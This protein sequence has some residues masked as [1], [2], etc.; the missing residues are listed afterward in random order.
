[1]LSSATLFHF[2]SSLETLKKILSEGFKPF[3][4]SEDLNMFGVA[5]CPGIPW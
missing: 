1:M 2:T 4:S 5:E 3:Y